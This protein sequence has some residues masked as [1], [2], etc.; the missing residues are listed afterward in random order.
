M[1]FNFLSKAKELFFNNGKSG[2]AAN[3]VQDAIDEVDAKV[4]GKLSTSGGTLTGALRGTE[5]LPTSEGNGQVG[6]GSTAWK[7]ILSNMFTARK[8]GVTYGSFQ[9]AHIEGTET[10]DGITLLTL[11]NNIK[12]GTKG[13][14]YGRIR[15]Y[16]NGSCYTDIVPANTDVNIGYNLPAKNGTLMLKEN[17]YTDSEGYLVIDLD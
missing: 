17:I 1:I 15:I 11:G 6:S 16:G 10:T 9:A 7:N 4:G 12:K 8:N 3:N 13:N 5:F 2:L 14:A